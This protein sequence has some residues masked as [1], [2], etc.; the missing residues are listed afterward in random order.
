MINLYFQFSC[1]SRFAKVDFAITSYLWRP[2]LT[3]C[4]WNQ[5]T[6]FLAIKNKDINNI[7]L[8]AKGTFLNKMQ[9]IQ[10]ANRVKKNR[11]KKAGDT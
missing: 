10:F 9:Q 6:V 1:K 4:F 5:P 3:F 2:N 11:N 7:Y 8:N